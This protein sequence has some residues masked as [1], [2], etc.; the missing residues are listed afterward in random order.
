[1]TSYWHLNSWR[2][3]NVL[4]ASVEVR[5]LQ[6]SCVYHAL[7]PLVVA[8]IWCQYAAAKLLIIPIGLGGSQS[9]RP[10]L[11]IISLWHNNTSQPSLYCIMRFEP[12]SFSCAVEYTGDLAF[13]RT[14][15][16][17]QVCP[18]GSRLDAHAVCCSFNRALRRANL[19]RTKC[20]YVGRD[21]ESSIY[22]SNFIQ[23]TQRRAGLE[24]CQ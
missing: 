4:Y 5:C 18:V 24:K 13:R 17:Q 21:S 10:Y 2:A 9:L 3:Y 22:D 11:T 7:L 14:R 20:A 12:Y 15:T 6:R 23:L 8:L 19:A 1:M 16:L